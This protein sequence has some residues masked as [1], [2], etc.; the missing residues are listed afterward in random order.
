[1]GNVLLLVW[2]Q[3]FKTVLS[4]AQTLLSSNASSVAQWRNGSAG[5]ILISVN[6]AIRSKWAETMCRRRQR[7][8]CHSAK[9]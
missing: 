7:K 9:G 8:N 4:M 2:G 6:H 5:G 1:M 3:G